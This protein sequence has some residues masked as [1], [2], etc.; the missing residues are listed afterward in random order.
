MEVE[1]AG[2]KLPVQRT[3]GKLRFVDVEVGGEQLRIMEQNPKKE[4]AWAEKARGRQGRG[5]TRGVRISLWKR[6]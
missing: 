4:S 3:A 1:L 5:H 2:K 6:T